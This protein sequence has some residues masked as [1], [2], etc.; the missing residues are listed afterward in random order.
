MP[1][2]LL[3]DGWS[4]L[5]FPEG[6]RSPHGQMNGLKTGAARLA[7]GTGAPIVPIGIRGSFAA[8][9]RGRSWPVPG[10]PRVNVRFGA[11]MR[12]LPHEG[13]KRYTNRV[14][15]RMNQLLA[16]DETT[17]WRSLQASGPGTD[18]GAARRSSEEQM[19]N[20]RRIWASTAPV[21][22]RERSTPWD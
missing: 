9:P 6:T 8:M 18:D 2:D 19:A 5:L 21:A 14:A 20:W 22:A 12:A 15:A 13:A 3:A 11:P 7:L 10:R 1:Q 4:L 16:E 17:W